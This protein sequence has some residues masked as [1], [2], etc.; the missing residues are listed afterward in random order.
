MLSLSINKQKLLMKFAWCLP[1]TFM[2]DFWV[3]KV[4]ESL[5]NRPTIKWDK[6]KWASNIAV[7]STHIINNVLGIK[8][9]K[10]W[11]IL[12]YCMNSK[13]HSVI[14][15][16]KDLNSISS[17]ISNVNTQYITLIK[18]LNTTKSITKKINNKL[19]LLKQKDK[20]KNSTMLVVARFLKS[21]MKKIASL[22]SLKLKI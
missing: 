8:R 18:W 5:F 22:N 1:D 13:I 2:K 4:L 19:I 3:A 6:K 16:Q 15:E 20:K 21:P 14:V 7:A 12:I 17:M 11:K 10:Y 9:E